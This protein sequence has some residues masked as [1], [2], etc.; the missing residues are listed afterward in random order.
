MP[1]SGRASHSS[2]LPGESLPDVAF[3]GPSS[4]AQA[5][6]AASW[7]VLLGTRRPFIG[8]RSERGH[9]PRGRLLTTVA[10]S[11]GLTV[12]IAVPR[13]GIADKGLE[14]MA[15]GTVK[16]FNAEKGFGF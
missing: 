15:T 16:W 12:G 13:R 6:A 2:G 11:H 9:D 5:V 14:L 10:S 7:R 8:S 1:P 3:M 4:P